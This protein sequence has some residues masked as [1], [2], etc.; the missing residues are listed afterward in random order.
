MLSLQR[1]YWDGLSDEYQRITRIALDDFHYGPQ[2]PGE[3]RL[4]LL[5]QIHPGMKAL[6]IGC[7]AAQNSIWLA[8]QGVDCTAMDISAEQLRHA[9]EIARQEE[10]S[11]RL[12]ECPMEKTADFAEGPFDL[13]HSSH[14]LEFTDD[15]AGVIRTAYELLRPGGHFVLSTVHPLYNGEW[16]EAEDDDA[17][18]PGAPVVE[19]ERGESERGLFLTSYFPPPDDVRYDGDGRVAVISRAHPVSAWFNWFREAGFEVTRLAEPPAVPPDETPPYTSDAWSVRDG[20]LE[21][22]PGTLI[23]VGLR[24]KAR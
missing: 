8:K 10:V 3:S 22:I 15:P 19:N 4:R 18:D 21:S 14:A 7:G 2:I 11:L 17:A 20:E 1:H 13:V 9:K 23:V 5:P 16:I 12:V 6:E 24:P